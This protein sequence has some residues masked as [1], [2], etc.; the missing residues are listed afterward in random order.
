VRKLCTIFLAALGGGI[1]WPPN[2]AVSCDFALADRT[3]DTGR[4]DND[5]L[6]PDRRS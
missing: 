1:L 4:V 6:T 2:E 3:S 5:Y